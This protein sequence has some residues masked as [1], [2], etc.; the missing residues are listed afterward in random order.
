MGRGLLEVCDF[1]N[2][3]PSELYEKH[4]PTI[5]DFMAV[6]AYYNVLAKEQDE[7]IRAMLGK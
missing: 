4:N 7:K 1:V 6:R 5:G 3:L 2:C